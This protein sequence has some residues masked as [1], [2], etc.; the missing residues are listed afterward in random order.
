MKILKLLFIFF[1]LNAYFIYPEGEKGIK[2]NKIK[3]NKGKRWA[4]CVGINDYND[5]NI[6][7]LKNAANDAINIGKIFNDNGQFDKVIT[8]VD[9]FNHFKNKMLPTKS[10]I[11]KQLD[12]ILN[13][14]SPEDLI[15]FTFSG[16]GISDN[17]GNGYL[18]TQDTDINKKFETSIKVQD[19]VKK[20]ENFKIK[21][22]LLILD[23]CREEISQTKSLGNKGLLA[24]KFK[25]SEVAATFYSTKAGWF[26]YEDTESEYGVFTRFLIDGLAGKADINNDK[27]VSFSEIETYVQDSVSEYSLKHNRKQKPYT[28]IYGEKFGDLALTAYK[29]KP[30]NT[31]SIS[32][33][34]DVK[35]LKDLIN[36]KIALKVGEEYSTALLSWAKA[37]E[38]SFDEIVILRNK[39]NP[40]T[41]NLKN[42]INYVEG[43]KIPNS[44]IIVLK[45]LKD[46]TFSYSDNTLEEDTT[47]YYKLF[48]KKIN[49]GSPI[50]SNNG[51]E[52]NVKTL[53]DEDTIQIRLDKLKV[54]KVLEEN[55]SWGVELCWKIEVE[56]ST[57][58]KFTIH[59]RPKEKYKAFED[60]KEYSFDDKIEI[61]LPKKDS[62]YFDIIVDLVDLD[63]GVKDGWLKENQQ[64]D[65]V[66]NKKHYRY[67]YNDNKIYKTHIIKEK[68]NKSCEVE[69]KWTISKAN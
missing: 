52:H 17:Q 48:T 14:S 2:I 24:E 53:I 35:S 20:F 59:E 34:E 69:L 6:V 30:E 7:D 63:T 25:E 55:K 33:I 65:K 37:K 32:I 42:N 38:S 61:K 66:I 27:V 41:F 43:E 8:L 45:I 68:E 10:N 21:K 36:F 15:I 50:Y 47:Y 26:S 51:I 22:T 29:T 5:D 62:S 1:I 60:G 12:Y 4:I 64:D 13:F 40:I 67:N 16:H 39:N 3:G 28:K 58:K 56:T 9:D 31:K 54:I 18:I 23:A 44:K 49:S 46:N 57:G 19:I 11:E